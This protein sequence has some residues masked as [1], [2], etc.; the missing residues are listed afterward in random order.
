MTWALDEKNKEFSPLLL[1]LLLLLLN[2]F[3]YTACS[4]V[5]S[6]CIVWNSGVGSSYCAH[7]SFLAVLIPDLQLH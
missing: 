7:P 6:K 5:Y 4:L 3:G 1:L 2:A